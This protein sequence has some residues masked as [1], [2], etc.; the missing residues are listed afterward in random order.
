MDKLENY[1]NK[2]SG[3]NFGGLFDNL[4]QNIENCISQNSIGSSRN[5]VSNSICTSSPIV[6]EVLWKTSAFKPVEKSTLSISDN[7]RI[8][9]QY[10]TAYFKEKIRA[11]NR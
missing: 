1:R 9:T 5:N 7:T 4:I 11:S 2:L 10:K 6:A 3:E 8:Y